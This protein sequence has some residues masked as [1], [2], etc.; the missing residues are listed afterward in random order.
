MAEK[1]DRKQLKQPDEFQVL[2]GKAMQW[3]ATHQAKVVTGIVAV[4]VVVLAGWG[5]SAWRA[6]REE[7]AGAALSDALEKASRPLA[8]EAI[9]GQPQ[10]TFPTKEEREKA[11]IAALQTVRSDFGGSRA[12]QTAQAQIAFHEQAS[13]DNAAAAKDLQEFLA[14]A[15]AGHPL[16]FVAQEA[17]GYALESQGKMDEAKAAF[18]KLSDFNMKPR[19]EFQD[20][21]LALVEGKPDAKA[22]LEKFAKDNPKETE[23]AREA[24]ARAELASLPPPSAAPAPAAAAPVAAPEP[25]KKAA[26]AP[27]KKK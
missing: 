25:A 5:F 24:N 4:A 15:G 21:R 13:G 23:L 17:L 14:S 27:K 11:V 8:S 20:A 3:V 12:A 2:A 19:A 9:P 7:K 16:R 18:D 26:P 22:Q 10:D 6:S 1:L